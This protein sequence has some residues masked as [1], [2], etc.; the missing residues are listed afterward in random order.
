MNRDIK[1][2]GRTKESV[3][4]QFETFVLPMHLEH[5]E[6]HKNDADIILNNNEDNLATPE[7]LAISCVDNS[8]AIHKK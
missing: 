4:E 2:R 1:E 7:E 3:I 8:I 5:V 6:P